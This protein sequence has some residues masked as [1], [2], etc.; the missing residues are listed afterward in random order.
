MERT[1]VGLLIFFLAGIFI[2]L[3]ARTA[4]PWKDEHQNFFWLIVL[5]PLF[6]TMFILPGHVSPNILNGIHA[7]LAGIIGCEYIRIKHGYKIN[8]VRAF[9]EDMEEQKKIRAQEKRASRGKR[10]RD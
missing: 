3:I 1:T 5:S 4:K 10:K 8:R 6:L 2:Y 9:R 7:L